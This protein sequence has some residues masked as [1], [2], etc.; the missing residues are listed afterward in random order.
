MSIFVAAEPE[1]GVTPN[2]DDLT[3]YIQRKYKK[4][5]AKA[6]KQEDP[7]KMPKIF[8]A[9]QENLTQLK[10]VQDPEEEKSLLAMTKEKIIA[11]KL[12]SKL[13]ERKSQR[14]IVNKSR[15][16]IV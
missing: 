1:V 8:V 11:L 3:R 16:E 5:R 10:Q 9:L 7:T 12:E 14:S 15:R 13:V 4:N 2:Y 6:H